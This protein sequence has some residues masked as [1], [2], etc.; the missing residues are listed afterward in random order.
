MT[1]RG[2]NVLHV[3]IVSAVVDKITWRTVNLNIFTSVY[4]TRSGSQSGPFLV[5]GLANFIHQYLMLRRAVVDAPEWADE[6]GD[7]AA[8]LY[9][10]EC[11]FEHGEKKTVIL[12][13]P[14]YFDD[15]RPTSARVNI[16]RNNQHNVMVFAV[17]TVNVSSCRTK[18]NTN[19]PIS[20]SYWLGQGRLLFFFFFGLLMVPLSI[21]TFGKRIVQSERQEGIN[22]M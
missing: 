9:K 17:I 6:L 4:P 15:C 19:L 7:S 5:I 16:S 11:I 21:R 18:R 10:T 8:V 2:I 13:P 3:Y 20:K 22:C 12:L 14:L 1:I